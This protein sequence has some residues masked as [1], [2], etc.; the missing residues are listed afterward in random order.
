VRDI[1]FHRVYENPSLNENRHYE[2]SDNFTMG[3]P[4]EVQWVYILANDAAL[5]LY[6]YADIN[7]INKLFGLALCIQ[8][9]RLR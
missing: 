9:G 6:G 2:K 4:I 8:F 1:K 5:G 7:S 3:I